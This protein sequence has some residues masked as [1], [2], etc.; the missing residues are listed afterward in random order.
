MRNYKL[1]HRLHELNETV[2][3]EDVYVLLSRSSESVA[4]LASDVA[5]EKIVFKTIDIENQP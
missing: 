4:V 5:T 1:H 2:P 3:G